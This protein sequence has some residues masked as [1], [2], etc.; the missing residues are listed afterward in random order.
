[1]NKVIV[2]TGYMGSGSSVITDLVSEFEGFEA[3][4]GTYEYVF[5]HCPNGVFDLEDKLLVGNNA[6]RS[7]E[8]LHSFYKTM[9]QLYNKKY[10]W[11]GHYKEVIGE[12]FLKITEE[13][14]EDLTQYKPQFYWY[15]QEN[16][17]VRMFFQLII[18]K[19][20]KFIS[21]NHIELKKP[22]LYSPMYISY[23]S[24]EEFYAKSK[25]YLARILDNLGI[26]EKN[27]I[28]DQFLLPFNLYRMEKY[29]GDNVEV[30]VIERDPRDMFLM[31][32]Y[33]Y[34]NRNEPVPYPTDV[35]EFCDC[36]RRLREMERRCE[37]EHIHRFKFE[38]FIYKYDETV[39]A[40]QQILGENGNVPPHVLKKEYFNPE[41]SIN[42]T[43]VFY[44]QSIYEEETKIIESQLAEYLY[45]FPY[46]RE[47][48]KEEMF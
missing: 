29:F 23:V 34:A 26:K 33:V 27:I 40:V 16:T 14:I 36:Y 22:L 44:N 17:N 48:K 37:N 38:D 6:I 24:K 11:V 25:K 1:M 4:R 39:A 20:V 15:Y 9:K 18:R 7:D 42:N 2:P 28:L 12:D 10:W 41:K 46:H 32:K 13:Y 47:G 21:L 19:I 43:Q 8:A 5:L 35:H 30:F 3:S 45:D 31:N